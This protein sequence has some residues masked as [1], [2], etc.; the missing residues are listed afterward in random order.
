[1]KRQFLKHFFFQT[2]A[3]EHI[4]YAMRMMKNFESMLTSDTKECMTAILYSMEAGK[5]PFYLEHKLM[6]LSR[7]IPYIQYNQT[8]SV[9]TIFQ[10]LTDS[11]NHGTI[12]LL[13]CNINPVLTILQM[14]EVSDQIK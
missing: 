1:M 13:V 14:L 5:A 2:L 10:M 12:G 6:L 4:N 11:M 8:E 9:M 3:M 7:F